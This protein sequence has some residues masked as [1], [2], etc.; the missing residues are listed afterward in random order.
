MLVAGLSVVAGGLGWSVRCLV[1]AALAPSRRWFAPV[2][3]NNPVTVSELR[4]QVRVLEPPGVG[5]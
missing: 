3:F 5:S 2:G 1:H 4:F